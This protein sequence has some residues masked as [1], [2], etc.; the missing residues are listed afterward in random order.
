MQALSAK[1][2]VRG[3]AVRAVQNGSKTVM[4][5][6][7]NWLPGNK[8]P[9][10]EYTVY[11]PWL[12]LPP[13]FKVYFYRL[14]QSTLAPLQILRIAT[15]LETSVMILLVS[16]PT[17]SAWTTSG[18]Q[19]WNKNSIL[20]KRSLLLSK[21]AP[22]QGSWRGLKDLNRSNLKCKTQFPFSVLPNCML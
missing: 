14:I 10:R 16:A 9:A 21:S 3:T 17:P 8:F 4:A 6:R 13:T 20:K 1:T 2:T 12:I 5:A 7:P 18:E 22:L 15:C 11:H 19:D